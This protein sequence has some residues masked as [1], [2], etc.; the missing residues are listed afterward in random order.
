MVYDKEI[1]KEMTKAGIDDLLAKHVAHLFIR[2]PI[3]LYK[4]KVDLDDDKTTE[5]FELIQSSNWMNMRFKPPT[6]EAPAIGWRVEFRPTEV[7]LTDFENAAYVVFVVLLTRVIISYNLSLLIPISQVNENMARAQRR[8]AP[9]PKVL[10][11]EG[12]C[13]LS[14][15]P[16]DGGGLRGSHG[17]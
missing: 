16:F 4:E 9:D 10:L 12:G 6:P 13:H 8:D 7:Q 3:Q 2:D 5:H 14:V 11:P 15:P 17:G 1:Y